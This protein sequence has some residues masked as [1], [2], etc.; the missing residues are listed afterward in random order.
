MIRLKKHLGILL[1]PS[2]QDFD[3]GALTFG[4]LFKDPDDKT[5][6]LY[7]TGSSCIRLNYSKVSIGLD[8]ILDGINFVKYSENPLISTSWV[9]VTPAVFKAMDKY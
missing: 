9:P 6:Y 5:G 1:E 7:Y 2:S 8:K 4:W 3:R